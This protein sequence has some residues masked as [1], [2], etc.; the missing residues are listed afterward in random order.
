MELIFDGDRTPT[1]KV[2]RYMEQAANLAFEQEGVRSEDVEVSV[3]FV[4]MEEIRELNRIY[5]KKDE[6]TDVLSF[7]QYGSSRDIPKEGKVSIG[8]V[9]LCTEQALLQADDFGH[10]PERELVYLFTHSIFHLLGYDHKVD[11]EKERMRDVEETIM[12]KVGLR[13]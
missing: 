7:P 13:K 2:I 3:S 5:R 10:S 9:V 11:E 8:D 4:D 1:E 6:V 12:S